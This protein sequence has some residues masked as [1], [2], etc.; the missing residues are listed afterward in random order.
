MKAFSNV[1]GHKC[2]LLIL[3]NFFYCTIRLILSFL[4]ETLLKEEVYHASD[5]CIPFFKTLTRV[6]LYEIYLNINESKQT[7]NT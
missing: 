1:N 3:G 4:L 6:D 5:A 7:L 2:N